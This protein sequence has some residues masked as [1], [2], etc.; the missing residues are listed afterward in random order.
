MKIAFINGSPKGQNSSS[1]NILNGLR[2]YL[3]NNNPNVKNNDNNKDIKDIS[4]DIHDFTWNRL[5]NKD[6]DF[7]SILECEAIV[8]SFPLYV[9]SIPSHLLR[10]LI[11]FDKYI[12]NNTNKS[13]NVYVILNNGFF[14]GKQNN[15]AVENIKNWCNRVGFSFKQGIGIGGGAMLSATQSI[16][17]GKG[18]NKSVGKLLEDMSDNI[19]LNKGDDF[20]YKESD[21]PAFVYKLCAQFGWRTM[22]KSNGLKSRDLNRTIKL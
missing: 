10:T 19:K 3:N 7:K 9:D 12:K 22:A 17:Y 21:I 5:S 18:I 15:I 14:D 6:E 13:M 4:I 11:D 20:R 16:D 2:D 8:F 1:F